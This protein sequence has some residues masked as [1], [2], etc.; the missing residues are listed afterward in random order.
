[1]A[2]AGIYKSEVVCARERL[3]AMGRNP[4]VDAVRT[5]LG[6]TG[7]K[8][9]IHRYLKEIDEEE[10]GKTGSKIAISESLQDLVG[11]LA[12]RVQEEA[13]ARIGEL[14]TAHA[15]QIKQLSD[16]AAAIREEL[17]SHRS[18]AER[19][20]VELAAERQRHQA[21]LDQLRALELTQTKAQQ[22][23]NGLRERL[24]A[25]EGH[26]QS[27]EEKHQHVQKSLEH[28]RESARE[29]RDQEGRK[30]E[31][32]TQFLQGEIR[33]VNQALSAKQHEAA[34]AHQENARLL[35]ELSHAQGSARAAQDE[36]RTLKGKVNGLSFAQQKSE[37]LI[38]RV[39]A[40]Q[41]DNL[42]LEEGAARQLR[43][44][45]ALADKY[46]QLEMEVAVKQASFDAQRDA[47]D[48]LTNR[49]KIEQVNV[50]SPR[51]KPNKP[52][53]TQPRE[54]L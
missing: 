28:F 29:Q 36:I 42:K 27:L 3:L 19:A 30:N 31:Q 40:L 25:E 5:E 39:A 12:A 7:S 18:G 20:T 26:R 9:T 21:A 16:S 38:V 15:V 24:A 54:L 53:A 52:A 44:F 50:K 41:A 48:L 13:D 37:E 49:L 11:R 10:G 22:E 51:P 1:M 35:S 34:T 23:L 8:T 45:L 43:E 6:D 46:R 4:S 17:A 33:T 2:R 14:T 47:V 32:Q